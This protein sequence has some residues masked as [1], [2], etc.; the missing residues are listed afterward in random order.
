MHL[1]ALTGTSLA[2]SCRRAPPFKAQ[3]RCIA[4]VAINL[5]RR[6]QR[7]ATG[8]LKSN[9]RFGR[10]QPLESLSVPVE[11]EPDRVQP[12]WKMSMPWKA[13]KT[14]DKRGI[15]KG[16]DGRW[17]TWRV[18]MLDGMERKSNSRVWSQWKIIIV[19]LSGHKMQR[20]K[21]RKKG[22]ERK[23]SE[24]CHGALNVFGSK[25]AMLCCNMELHLSE[26]SDCLSIGLQTEVQCRRWSSCQEMT[27]RQ[28]NSCWRKWRSLRWALNPGTFLFAGELWYIHVF[29]SCDGKGE[30]YAA[31]VLLNIFVEIVKP[32]FKILWWI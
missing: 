16:R 5:Q 12:S 23:L 21:A 18:C 30:F 27:C 22:I 9:K 4:P 10:A 25:T 28:R 3:V 24:E 19:I 20:Q 7:N 6:A 1:Q 26:W 11:M 8:T 13:V 32:F 29:I 15:L 31:F 14:K 2:F 17:N